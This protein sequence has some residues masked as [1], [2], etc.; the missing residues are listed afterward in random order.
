METI[1]VCGVLVTASPEHLQ[2]VREQLEEESG[3]EV[4]ATTGEGRMVVTV[5]KEDQQQTG[6]MLEKIQTLDHVICASMVYQYF[7]QEAENKW[8]MAS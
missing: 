2:A 6:D 5:E 8:E 4:H 3:V 7:D 1:N